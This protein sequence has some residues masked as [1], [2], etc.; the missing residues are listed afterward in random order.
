MMQLPGLL[1]LQELP[2]LTRCYV[3]ERQK[4]KHWVHWRGKVCT[5]ICNAYMPQGRERGELMP[6]KALHLLWHR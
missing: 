5:A 4:H 6:V 1:G 3:Q 2:H